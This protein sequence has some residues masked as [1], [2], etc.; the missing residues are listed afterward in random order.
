MLLAID[1]G[2]TNT[3]FSIWDGTGFLATWRT[4][5]EVNRTADQYYV[6]L[7][8]LMQLQKID[9]K[10]TE[11]IVSSTVPRVVFNLR[12]LCNRY[13]DTRPY[14]VG[15]PDC[16]LPIDVRVDA[17]TA[18]GPDRL[19]NTVAGF[20]LYGGDLIV[21]DFGTA[22]TFDVVGAD[23]AYVGGVIAPG[24]NLSLQALHDAAAALP[25]VDV[26]M[27]PQVVGRNTVD[28]MQSGIFWGYVGLVSGLVERIRMERSRPMKVIGTGGLAPLFQQGDALFDA[29]E[30]NLTMHGL[31]V[32]YRH[33]KDLEQTA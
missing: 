4:A 15:K 3:V 8:T 31:T 6:W 17:G 11:V 26:T 22:T 23:G 5:T 14:V 21:V 10:I 2:N 9:V 32:I 16:A 28:C 27:P 25:L 29:F 12:V 1:C 24:V 30:D 20:D 7:S 18:V 33:N 19:V 13:F